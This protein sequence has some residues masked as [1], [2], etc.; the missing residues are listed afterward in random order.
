MC[1]PMH[2][3]KIIV[4]ASFMN[5]FGDTEAIPGI[6]S[7]RVVPDQYC[8][9]ILENNQTIGNTFIDVLQIQDVYKGS[10]AIFPIRITNNEFNDKEYVVSV[11]GLD[12]WGYSRLEPG[13]LII[14]PDGTQRAIDLYV[15]AYNNAQVYPGERTF[16][17]SIQSGE[18]VQRFLLIANVKESGQVNN[19]FLWLF[20]LRVILIG[21]LIILIIVALIIGIKK[22]ADNAKSE[23]NVQYY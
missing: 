16:V 5:M 11:T 7:I 1:V 21:G 15:G 18:E 8:Q 19:S 20:S 14:V 13:S 3:Y 23:Q 9:M 17:V 22:Y 2:D 4:E 6:T 10:E 12:N